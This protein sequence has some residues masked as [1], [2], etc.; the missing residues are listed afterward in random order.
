MF[1]LV[2]FLSILLLSFT[3]FAQSNTREFRPGEPASARGIS[4]PDV[5]ITPVTWASFSTLSSGAAP[6]TYSA[7]RTGTFYGG[8]YQNYLVGINAYSFLFY[9]GITRSRLIYIFDTASLSL[10]SGYLFNGTMT[11]FGDPFSKTLEVFD[12]EDFGLET[13]TPTTGDGSASAAANAAGTPIF[14]GTITE[15]DN[16]ISVDVTEQV[17]EDINASDDFSGFVMG[18]ADAE[19]F[20]TG[21]LW[22]NFNVGLTATAPPVTIPTMGEWTLIGFITLMMG[23]A[24]VYS[25]RQRRQRQAL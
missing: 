14:T 25:V 24:V 9:A 17:W 13:G 5:E 16:N 12:A 2:S 20:G 21:F 23:L 4:I 22:G 6:A 15:G 10:N 8:T 11:A 7:D 18:L 1:R 19:P 3:A